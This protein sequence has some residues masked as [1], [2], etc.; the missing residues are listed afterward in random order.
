MASHDEVFPSYHAK[1][2]EIDA[3]WDECEQRFGS[4]PPPLRGLATQFLQS[5]ALASGSHRNYFS[6]PLAPPLLY[7]PIWLFDSLVE[8]R[9]LSPA[10]HSALIKILAGTIQGYLH[11]RTQDDVLDEPARAD[12]NLLL[13]G[14]A[15]SSGMVAA[16]VEA[17]GTH[18][19]QFWTEYD[20]A[21][22][23]FS[24]LTLAEQHAVKQ[25]NFYEVERFDEHAD[26]VAFARIPLLAVAALASRFDMRPSICSLVH[27]L[28]IAYGLVNDVVGW[29]RDLRAGHR[30][31]LLATAGLTHAELRH[32]HQIPDDTAR[33]A[34]GETLAERLRENLYQGRLL[35]ESL[36]R[37]LHHHE[38]ARDT[39]RALGLFGFEQFH[40]DRTAWLSA[41]DEIGALTLARVLRQSSRNS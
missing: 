15:C 25:D 6:D 14:N 20:R 35:H 9:Q 40:I 1:R 2:A 31:H 18:S 8:Q 21:V 7:M 28:G 29:T 34:A 22:V 24:C 33:T 13:F 36:G 32:L 41:L 11:I 39:A 30:T 16:Y 27:E 4:L 26:K 19:S 5:I 23:D 37:A 12:A 10:D 3:A 38:R 17:L